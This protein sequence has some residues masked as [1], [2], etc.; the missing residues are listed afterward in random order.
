[1]LITTLTNRSYS[2]DWK[3]STTTT[4]ASNWSSPATQHQYFQSLQRES[5]WNWKSTA[6]WWNPTRTAAPWQALR[7]PWTPN[8]SHCCPTTTSRLPWLLLCRRSRTLRRTLEGNSSR[9]LPSSWVKRFS[10]RPTGSWRLAC[11]CRNWGVLY[12]ST[13]TTSPSTGT[14]QSPVTSS[15]PLEHPR[16]YGFGRDYSCLKTRWLIKH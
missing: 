15:M 10:T 9:T 12:T 1:M 7:C 14:C 8:W 5:S 4:T 6:T 3:T 2:P 13:T 11:L 16:A